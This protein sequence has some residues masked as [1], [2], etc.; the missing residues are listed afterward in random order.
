MKII[1]Y[2]CKNRADFERGGA[3]NKSRVL[4]TIF[5]LLTIFSASIGKNQDSERAVLAILKTLKHFKELDGVTELLVKEF[6]QEHWLEMLMDAL[7]K[8]KSPLNKNRLSQLQELIE[9]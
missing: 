8:A 7:L 4:E 1:Q 2:G 5:S 9:Q 6:G 3:L